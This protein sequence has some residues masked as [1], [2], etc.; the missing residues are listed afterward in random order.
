MLCICDYARN[1]DLNMRYDRGM[2]AHSVCINTFNFSLYILAT[3]S[4]TLIS[5][6]H[7]T[8][9]VDCMTGDSTMNVFWFSS[10]VITPP[11][12]NSVNRKHIKRIHMCVLASKIS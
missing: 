10:N 4:L 11:Q 9:L 1:T 3:Q 12:S 8:L 6:V 5:Q 2:I 7:V